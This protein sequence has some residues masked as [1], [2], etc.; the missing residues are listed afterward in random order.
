MIAL[1]VEEYSV[2]EGAGRRIASAE[3]TSEVVRAACHTKTGTA[4]ECVNMR[5]LLIKECDGFS[6]VVYLSPDFRG[7]PSAERKTGR[8]GNHSRFPAPSQPLL[9]PGYCK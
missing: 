2:T 4:M 3:I 9:N 5:K 8:A 1:A 7:S 6:T